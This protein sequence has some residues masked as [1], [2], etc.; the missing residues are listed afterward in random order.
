MEKNGPK[1]NRTDTDENLLHCFENF[2]NLTEYRFIQ[3][4]VRPLK[5]ILK[6]YMEDYGNKYIDQL[7][8]FVTILKPRRNCSTDFITK[9]V[10]NYDFLS[11]L[12]SKPLREFRKLRFK[13]V[14]T[15]RIL[16]D[17]LP[18]R[19]GYKPQ[20]THKIFENVSIASTKPPIYTK[21]E[22]DKLYVVNFPKRVDQSHLT[23]ESVTMESVSNE[24][25]QLFP[26]NTVK[27]FINFKNWR[28]VSN[29][30]LLILLKPWTRS[31]KRQKHRKMYHSQRLPQKAQK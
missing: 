21:D 14:D 17:D 9:N 19:K 13:I 10:R 12:N 23:M 3:W 5:N 27:S 24:S 16:K 2:S 26:D 11:I 6:R 25:A 22:Q 4:F 29:I 30:P 1:R 20:F 8:Q 15:D 18:F 31:F 7:A 28:L